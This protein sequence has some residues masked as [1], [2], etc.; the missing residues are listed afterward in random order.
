MCLLSIGLEANGPDFAPC[1]EDSHMFKGM[2][3]NSG[4]GPLG[5]AAARHD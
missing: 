2:R 4:D 1:I 3:L 5:K